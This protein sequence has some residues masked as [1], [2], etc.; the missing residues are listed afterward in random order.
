MDFFTGSRVWHSNTAAAVLF[1]L[2]LLRGR[3]KA[4]GSVGRAGLAGRAARLSS[5]IEAATMSH[6]FAAKKLSASFQEYPDYLERG[7]VYGQADWIASILPSELGD[8]KNA[9]G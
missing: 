6:T 4:A 1:L 7:G 3:T 2:P 5:L 9:G 8:G